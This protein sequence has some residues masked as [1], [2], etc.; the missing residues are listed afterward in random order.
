[1]QC[2]WL[3]SNREHVSDRYKILILYILK[4]FVFLGDNDGLVRYILSP[5][6]HGFYK[7]D[8]TALKTKTGRMNNTD[9]LVTMQCS[10]GKP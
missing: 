5:A 1:M 6:C 4:K 10:G 7:F 9:N 2:I 3:I 8:P